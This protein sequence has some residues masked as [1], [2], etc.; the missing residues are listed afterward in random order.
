MNGV[1]EGGALE[2]P[3]S[4]QGGT[5]A[6]LLYLAR[7]SELEV[8]RLGRFSF[9][10]GYYLY[11]GSAMGGL[12]ARLG[13]H[14]AGPKNIHWHID[15]LAVQA[16]LLEIWWQGGNER[17][18]C[19]WASLVQ[20]IPNANLPVAGFGSSDCQCVSHLVHVSYR[21]SVELLQSETVSTLTMSHPVR[22]Q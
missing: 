11:V 5:Y 14:V 15:Y 8:G 13:R 17:L 9:P 12:K 3:P 22:M 21:P 2:P 6:L 19:A 10:Q 16:E 4:R 7:Q 1:R 20:A 18:E